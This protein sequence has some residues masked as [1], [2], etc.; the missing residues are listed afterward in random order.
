MLTIELSPAMLAILGSAVLEYQDGLTEEVNM[1]LAAATLTERMTGL[2]PEPSDKAKRIA[3]VLS[4][5]NGFNDEV[6]NV[7]NPML[8]ALATEELEARYE[9]LFGENA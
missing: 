3:I 4:F 6:A 9:A 8:S 1:E 5:L 7:Y 2:L